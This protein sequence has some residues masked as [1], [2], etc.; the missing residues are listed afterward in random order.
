[1]L[2]STGEGGTCQLNKHSHSAKIQK[3]GPSPVLAAAM[4]RAS[5]LRMSG[6]F[7]L[8]AAAC[9]MHDDVLFSRGEALDPLETAQLLAGKCNRFVI[10][11]A[12]VIVMT[13]CCSACLKSRFR[14]DI[15][16]ALMSA[17]CVSGVAGCSEQHSIAGGPGAAGECH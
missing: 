16:L 17:R 1:M 11:I 5:L 3:S 10:R 2:P 7:V 4:M 6:L 8:L 13:V 12:R 15:D 14:F 9:C